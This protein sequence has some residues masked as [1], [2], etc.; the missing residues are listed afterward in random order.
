METCITRVSRAATFLSGTAS[1]TKI[2]RFWGAGPTILN[3]LGD[4]NADTT[5]EPDEDGARVKTVGRA[6]RNTT[7]SATRR[8]L[9][10]VEPFP[11]R[12]NCH[13]SPPRIIYGLRNSDP[14][15]A[16]LTSENPIS[17]QKGLTT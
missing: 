17:A 7:E 13:V 14:N 4:G 16:P 9:G 11:G 15:L 8:D 2:G 5:V 6:N 3:P 12:N 10:D 1:V